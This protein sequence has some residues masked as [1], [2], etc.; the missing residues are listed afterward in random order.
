MDREKFPRLRSLAWL[1]AEKKSLIP[2]STSCNLERLFQFTSL[3][4]ERS[5]VLIVARRKEPLFCSRSDELVLTQGVFFFWHELE[6]HASNALR[7]GFQIVFFLTYLSFT[8]PFFSFRRL[9]V[10]DNCF[11]LIQLDYR[12][13]FLIRRKKISDPSTILFVDVVR[14][15]RCLPVRKCIVAENFS[16]KRRGGSPVGWEISWHA[17]DDLKT[18]A[19]RG[20]VL[21]V[22]RVRFFPVFEK[23]EW[24]LPPVVVGLV[25]VKHQKRVIRSHEQ[26]RSVVPSGKVGGDLPKIFMPRGCVFPDLAS[27]F[28]TSNYT[29]LSPSCHSIGAKNLLFWREI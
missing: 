10:R 6:E 5:V 27:C 28:P 23:A 17:S 2:C 19:A 16:L 8:M 1:I 7:Y 14:L 4:V 11:Y 22:C 26:R 3:A 24:N 13:W 20:Q 29:G 18:R 25:A 9:L 21:P 12:F 15:G